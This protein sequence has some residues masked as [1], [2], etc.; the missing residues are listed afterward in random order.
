MTAIDFL[1]QNGITRAT[2]YT[3]NQTYYLNDLAALLEEYADI[4]QNC[5]KHGVMQAEGSDVRS[6]GEQLGNEAGVKAVCA[7]GCD[8]TD[9]VERMGII[10]CRS[11]G[12]PK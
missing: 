8:E 1:K 5:I 2:C 11:C 7:D 12:K 9:F 4:K 10:Q 6:E 3:E